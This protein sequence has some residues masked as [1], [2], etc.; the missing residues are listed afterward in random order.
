[1]LA[2]INSAVDEC[3]ENDI[4]KEFLLKHRGE[5]C[6]VILAEYNEKL[7]MENEREIGRAEGKTEGIQQEIFDSVFQND[8]SA[9]RGAEKLKISK[10]EFEVKYQRWLKKRASNERSNESSETM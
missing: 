2:A 4:L 9:E 7:H 5:V 10:E 8:Y 3:I 1:M 6:Q